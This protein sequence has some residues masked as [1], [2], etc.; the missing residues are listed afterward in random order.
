MFYYLIQNKL[1]E[2]K[3]ADSCN[4]IKINYIT[5]IHIK[6]WTSMQRII[7]IVVDRNAKDM[8]IIRNSLTLVTCSQIISVTEV[9]VVMVPMPPTFVTDFTT[10]SASY[11]IFIMTFITSM[12]IES[13]VK[14]SSTIQSAFSMMFIFA[15][16]VDLVLCHAI[17]IMTIM[18]V[19]SLVPRWLILV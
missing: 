3:L 14:A 5:V 1:A 2:Q 7:D 17:I 12:V 10:C 18:K 8:V 11:W 16:F 15:G 19:L 9:K 13:T 4:I 6:D